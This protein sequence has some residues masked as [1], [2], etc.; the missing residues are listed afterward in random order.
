MRNSNNLVNTNI[1]LTPN[2]EQV[3]KRFQHFIEEKDNRVFILNGY[4]G[5]GKTTLIR[6]FIEELSKRDKQYV[7]M[8]S[9]GRAAKILSNSTGKKASTVHSVI[10]KFNDF[11]QDLEEVVKQE[12]QYGI[13]KTG[14][15]Y[16]TF[17][18]VPNTSSTQQFY[19][20]DEA[21]MIS[22]VKDPSAVQAVFGSGK[23]LSDLLEYNVNAKFIF[24][25]DVCQLPPILQDISPALSSKYLKEVHNI[26]S[27]ETTLTS[28]VRQHEDN[29]IIQASHRIRNLYQDPPVIKWGKLPLGNYKDIRLHTDTISM[30]NK[31]LELIRGYSYERGTF[32]S[33]SNSKC[34]NLN[35]L[36]RSTLGYKSTLQVGDLL[37]V[38]QNNSLSGFMNGDMVVIEQIKNVR[39][40][41]AQLTFLQVEVKELVTGQRFTQLLIENILYDNMT[42]LKHSEQK[43]LFIDFYR[44][45]KSEGINQKNPIFKERLHTDEYLNALRCVFGYA[46][47]CHKAQ[48]GEWD[49]VCIDIPRNLT[50]NAKASSYQWVY[51]AVTRARKM[52]HIVNDFYISN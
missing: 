7:L 42:N 43:A 36:I 26:D 23:L 12:D 22:D 19:I 2:Q 17:S 5:T 41:R 25:G 24:V 11:N 3:F 48:G 21:S 6:F 29:T 52:L 16:L 30:I 1:V 34:N 49:E 28:I 47:T 45:M 32:I 8:A 37:L 4:A 20:I 40:Q 44:R 33:Y 18:M 15:L 35:K 27:I 13:D 51:T 10:Y 31:Y 9:T 39:Y 14:Q 46:L 38:T 50:L